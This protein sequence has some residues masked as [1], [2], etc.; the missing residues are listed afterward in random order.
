[1][2]LSVIA[3]TF[4]I[5]PIRAQY[6]Y[7][8]F[9]KSKVRFSKKQNEKLNQRQ[10][11]DIPLA[12]PNLIAVPPVNEETLDFREGPSFSVPMGSSY[13]IYSVV[14]EGPNPVS[15][16]PDIN[17]IIFC[18]RQNFP[19]PGGSG[20]MSF[21]VST[22]AGVSWDTITRQVTPSLMTP[23]GIGLNGNRYPNGSIY[24]PPGN[25]D[26][27]N[28]FFVGTGASLWNDPAFGSGWGYEWVASAKLDGSLVDEN[29]YSTADTNIYL[30]TGMT[31]NPDGSQWY[32]NYRREQNFSHQLY[33]PII[34]TKLEFN[35]T[36]NNFDRTPF[37]LPLNYSTGI[38]S[39]AINPRIAFAPDGQIGYTVTTGIDGDDNEILSKCK[40]YYLEDRRW[41]RYLGKTTKGSIS[42]NGFAYCMDYPN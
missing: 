39:F 12:T 16:H 19:Y 28:A 40:T 31:Y 41:R 34:A 5:T 27:A 21:D 7:Q 9:D 32:A 11:P 10:L 35:S 33:N 17:T 2:Y 4:L 29:Y 36:N 20:I 30:S 8:N 26:P 14:S 1:M 25:T 18:H 6:T 13:N 22:D 3:F 15:Y 38:D 37:E 42:T 23:D 24:N